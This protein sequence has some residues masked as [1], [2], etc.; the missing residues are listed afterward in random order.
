MSRGAKRAAREARGL[1]YQFRCQCGQRWTSGV[2]AHCGDCHRHFA[3]LTAMDKHARPNRRCVDPS[4]AGMAQAQG[5]D[6]QPDYW[7]FRR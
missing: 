3:S 4:G 1:M 6:G 5:K 2:E 7:T